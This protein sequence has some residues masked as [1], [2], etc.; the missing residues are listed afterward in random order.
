MFIIRVICTICNLNENYLEVNN[1]TKMNNWTFSSYRGIEDSFGYS[2]YD[3][4]FRP[5]IAISHWANETWEPLGGNIGSIVYKTPIDVTNMKR[6]VMNIVLETNHPNA[7]NYTTIGLCKFNNN[8]KYE[9]FSNFVV[10]EQISKKGMENQ[11]R[12]IE[13]N[14]SELTGSYYLKVTVKHHLPDNG[15]MTSVTRFNSLYPVYQ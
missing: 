3:T 5:F 13:L 1:E 14:V 8:E 7:T 10:S 12:K 9:D 6:I 11:E 15:V 4:T 2:M